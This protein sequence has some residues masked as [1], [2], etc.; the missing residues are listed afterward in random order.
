MKTCSLWK[1]LLTIA[2]V[3]TCNAYG[4]NGDSS[5]GNDFLKN[6]ETSSPKPA[7]AKPVKPATQHHDRRCELGECDPYAA[8]GDDDDDDCI[9][10]WVGG[11]PGRCFY[12]DEDFLYPYPS[13]VEGIDRETDTWPGKRED[14][15]Y[16]ALTR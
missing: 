16:D 1:T 6:Y 7:A 10:N 15:F 13:F 4:S 12:S 5:T 9:G 14:P 8:E 3:T 2:F 11:A